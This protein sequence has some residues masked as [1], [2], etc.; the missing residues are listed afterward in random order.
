[1]DFI[2]NILIVLFMLSAISAIFLV[3]CRDAKH[4]R[5]LDPASDVRLLPAFINRLYFV[6]STCS[7]VGF[8]DVAPVSMRGKLLTIAVIL[9]V[10]TLVAKAFAN[11]IEAY[12]KNVKQYLRSFAQTAATTADPSRLMFWKPRPV[13]NK[14]EP[15][16]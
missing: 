12:N 15:K 3:V 5:G 9:T 2:V 14:D 13:E 10:F 8:G 11:Y 16:K 1:M 7:T 6:V 4:F